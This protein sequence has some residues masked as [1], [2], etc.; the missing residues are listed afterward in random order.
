[1]MHVLRVRLLCLT[2]LALLALPVHR[3]L[4]DNSAKVDAA[5]RQVETGA[6]QIGQGVEETAKGIGNT[7]LEGAKLTGEKVQEAGK[8]VEPQARTAWQKV[9]DG[10]NSF[11]SGVKD[12]F[13]KTFGN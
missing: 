9:K 13:D 1:M 8:A 7:V 6:K 11:A 4:A 3:V 5:T 12:F 2:M 10:T